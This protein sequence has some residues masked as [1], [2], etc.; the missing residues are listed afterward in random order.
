MPFSTTLGKK[1]LALGLGGDGP[2][3]AGQARKLARHAD[4][5]GLVTEGAIGVEHRGAVGKSRAAMRRQQRGGQD[6]AHH[7]T[8]PTSAAVEQ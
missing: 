6:Q 4:A 1:R 3:P 2:C 7:W 5:A 8:A